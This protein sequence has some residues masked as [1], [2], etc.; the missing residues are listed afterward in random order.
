[1]A[2]ATNPLTGTTTAQTFLV[3]ETV[4]LRSIE[5]EDARWSVALRDSPYPVSPQ[6]TEKW[7]TEDLAGQNPWDDNTTLAIRRR[8]DDVI[9]GSLRVRNG[10]TF[11]RWEVSAHVDPLYGPRS[12]AWKAEAIEIAVNWLID[13]RQMAMVFI[14]LA[15]TEQIVIDRLVA[16]GMRETTRLRER[17]LHDGKRVDQ[18]I[19][20]QFNPAWLATVGD[21]AD[22]ILPRT[23]IGTP[24]P[25]PLRPEA[26]VVAPKNAV[27][28]GPRV[29]LRPYTEADIAAYVRWDRQEIVEPFLLGRNLS[30]L[31][32]EL[33]AHNEDEKQDFPEFIPLAICLRD[34][35][36]YIGDVTLIYPDFVNRSAE[37]ASWLH[38][39]FRAQGYGS[40]AKHLLLEYAFNILG[41]HMIESWVRSENT[42]SAAALRKQGYR[43]AG[44]L[45]WNSHRGGQFTNFVTF[46]LL[47]EEWRNLNE[48]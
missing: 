6:R 25:R 5:K 13:E 48:A 45:G 18:V 17:Y 32:G 9:V 15:A 41:L 37:T 7:I 19:L 4:Y 31:A 43:E 44:M 39:A 46:D 20:Q 28:V 29:Y 30:S 14:R 1:V 26:T 35:D 36:A 12:S 33:H 3:G 22:Q 21:P 42:R 47:A 40:E 10:H 24:R 16:S 2:I 34:T 8:A 38:H 27:L 23:G 11:L